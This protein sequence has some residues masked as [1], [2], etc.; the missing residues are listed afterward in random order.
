MMMDEQRRKKVTLATMCIATF[1]AILDTTVVNLGLHAIQGGLHA[2]VTVLQWVLDVYNLV[3]A[4][5]ILT[6]GVLG[7][8]FGRRRIFIVGIALFTLGSLVCTLAPNAVVLL[9]GRGIAGLG[10]A[11]QLPGALSILTV[12]FPDAGERARAI[13][14][15]GGFNGLAMAVGPTAGGLLV[16]YFG[17]RSIFYL[18]VPF[19]VI[20]L[21]MA[22]YGV[23]ES[24]H[25]QGRRIDLT[26]QIFAI[27]ALGLLAFAFIEAP[28]LKWSSPVILGCLFGSGVSL[29]AL[30]WT[31]SRT[32]G[33]MISLS[34]FRNRVFATSIANAAMMTFG[35]YTLLFIFPLYL[36]QAQGN[37]AVVAGLKLLP[38]SLTFFLLSPLAGKLLHRVGARVLIGSGM[39]LFG[40]GLWALGLVIHLGFSAI[41]PALVAIGL[42]NALVFGPIMTVAVSSVGDERSG[43]SSGLVNV[44]RMVGATMA[45]AIPGSIFG[46]HVTSGIP[47]TAKF[48]AGMHKAF[49]IAGLDEVAG[50]VL[51]F[52]FLRHT[53]QVRRMKRIEQREAA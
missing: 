9:C 25:P 49:F 36:Q 43:M 18:V 2:S 12:T 16:D 6:G 14:I 8:M 13:A 51:A 35:F 50:G 29:L 19:G 21:A 3:Y 23:S 30:L 52:S 48:M 4:G 47:D 15:W 39:A 7:D 1:V 24:S 42:G 37:S 20:A 22:V 33:A 11:L 28:M 5:F 34:A 10:A 31:E 26:G 46:A 44:A 27:M 45:V 38:L 53:V 32:P 17:W 41:A 40:V